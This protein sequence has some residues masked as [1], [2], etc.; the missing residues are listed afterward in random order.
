MWLGMLMNPHQILF[1]GL[2]HL[3]REGGGCPGQG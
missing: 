3:S 2:F 1:S